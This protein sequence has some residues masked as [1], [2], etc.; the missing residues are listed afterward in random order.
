MIE[1]TSGD[2]PPIRAHLIHRDE[3][4][5][6]V[7]PVD[8]GFVFETLPLIEDG[9]FWPFGYHVRF[10]YAEPISRQGWGDIEVEL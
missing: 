4:I 1:V 3:V 2:N 7:E 8:G 10:D 6:T 5:E 9:G